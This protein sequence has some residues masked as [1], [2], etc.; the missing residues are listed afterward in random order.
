MLMRRRPG[1]S[2][3]QYWAQHPSPA[4]TTWSAPPGPIP[5]PALDL[6]LDAAAAARRAAPRPF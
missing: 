4:C 1:K 6:N 5:A 3:H 2:M